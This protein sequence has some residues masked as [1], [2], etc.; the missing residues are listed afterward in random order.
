MLPRS[1]LAFDTET[2][3]LRWF[4]TDQ[5]AFLGSLANDFDQWIDVFERCPDGRR[6]FTSCLQGGECVFAHNLKFDAH[7]VRAISKYDIMHD[8]PERLHDTSLMSR[9]LE[10]LG[11]DG[12]KK[13][14]HKLKN[15]AKTI[16]SEDAKDAEDLVK[17]KFQELTGRRQ[18]DEAVN[19]D[20]YYQV[21]KT[22]PE[23]LENYAV[24]DARYTYDLGDHFMTALHNADAKLRSLYELERRNQRVLYDAE[25]RGLRVDPG[26]V[27]RLKA[28]YLDRDRAAERQLVD[29]LG[30]VPVGDGS[31]EQL[32]TALID[33]GVK[34]TEKNED[35]SY[36]TNRQA[37]QRYQDHP[38]VAALFEWRRTQKFLSTYIRPMEGVDFVHTSF[39]EAEAW[40]GRS[41]CASPNMQ[42]LPKR[43]EGDLEEN[44][45]VRSVIVPREGYSF[46]ILD[47]EAVEMRILAHYLGV[48]WYRELVANGDPHA[49]TA[50]VIW[51]GRPEDYFKGTPKRF[52]RDIAKHSTFAIVY[53][54]GG[55][56][57]AETINRMV[58]DP[59]LRVTEAQGR[60]IR[61]KI[62][63]AIPGYDALA[64]TRRGREGRLA[65]RV[66]EVGYVTTIL[67]RHQVINPEKTYVALSGIVQGSG[68][69]IMKAAAVNLAE[70]MP[71]FDAQPLLFVHDE[72]LIEVPTEL[73]ETALPVAVEAMESAVELKPALKVEAHITQQSY[74]HGD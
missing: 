37:L 69:D 10:P 27:E 24:L 16:L 56:K 57:V 71:Q 51:G 1:S 44:L 43:S 61:N 12:K 62:V 45:R 42:N 6:N 59:S 13:G 21:W 23:I 46:L 20:A 72:A 33:A 48:P 17:E 40:S 49:L 8:R 18:I 54:A 47:F 73:A 2:R 50:S 66:H 68:A 5:R 3:G 52:L 74:A 30:F 9:L 63:G 22:Y 25:V 14:S 65:R 39:K 19:P 29:T 11:Q 34:L 7:H 70:A 4:D 60:I 67:G 28:H 58:P 53:G 36:S 32:A 35:G 38:A 26:A 64:G 31:R 15:L 41:A 55:P